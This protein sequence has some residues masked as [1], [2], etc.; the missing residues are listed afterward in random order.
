MERSLDSKLHSCVS[1]IF[2]CPIMGW[3]LSFQ[4]LLHMHILSQRVWGRQLL[5][6]CNLISNYRCVE[7]SLQTLSF[8]SGFQFHLRCAF[9]GP[10]WDGATIHTSSATTARH[11]QQTWESV[12]T[13]RKCGTAA[14]HVKQLIGLIISC[15]VMRLAPQLH[16]CLNLTSPTWFSR[17]LMTAVSYYAAFGK[18]S[19]SM[20]SQS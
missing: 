11:N 4:V 1:S 8:G 17:S 15:T 5:T 3:V 13:A 7:L 20:A 9:A 2:A 18:T 12:A 6:W 14:N 16:P 10:T 19:A